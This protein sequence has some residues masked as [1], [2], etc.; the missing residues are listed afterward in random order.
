VPKQLLDPSYFLNKTLPEHR[1]YRIIRALDSG[2]NAQVF[3]AH[4][5]SLARDIACKVI[6]KENLIGQDKDP[7]AWEAEIAN[8]NQVPSQRV[9][10]IFPI[11]T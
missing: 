5:D 4:S 2:R 6:P 8:A 10:K 7:P 9:V 1:E 3:V 11:G